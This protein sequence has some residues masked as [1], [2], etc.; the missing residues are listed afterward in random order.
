MKKSIVLALAIGLMLPMAAAHAE[1]KALKIGQEM[2]D[3]ELPGTDGEVHTLSDLKGKIVVLQF[4]S[5]NCPY[6]RGA[7]PDISKMAKRFEDKGVALYGIDADKD[8]TIATIKVYHEENDIEYVTLKDKDNE[9]A[10]KVFARQTPEFFVVDKEGKLAYHGA[11]DNR[12]A[13]QEAGDTNYVV[14]AVNDLLEDKP[15]E[16]PEVS[17]W[18]CSIARAKKPNW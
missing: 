14:D 7:D 5:E 8:T 10:D 13:P 3:F 1:K 12:V 18:G 4:C 11:I 2:P 9:Y 17:A 15:V 16:K 6:S